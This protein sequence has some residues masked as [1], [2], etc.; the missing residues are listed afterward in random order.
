[1]LIA[2]RFVW[3]CVQALKL[4]AN[5]MYGCLGFESSRFY[6]KPL[7]SLITTQGIRLVRW[8][9]LLSRSLH[10]PIAGGALTAKCLHCPTHS[11]GR[12]ILQRTKDTAERIGFT[13]PCHRDARVVLG[14]LISLISCALC[15]YDHGVASGHLR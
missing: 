11:A 3:R 9:G 8:R 1:M 5:S 6:C 4:V 10:M 13:V 12:E 14:Q 7:A 15:M 2:L